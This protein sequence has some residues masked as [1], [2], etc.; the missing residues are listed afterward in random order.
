LGVGVQAAASSSPFN[1]WP[2][3]GLVVGL[4]TLEGIQGVTVK[5][6]KINPV[7]VMMLNDIWLLDFRLAFIHSFARSS[8]R[9]SS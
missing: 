4:S 9:Q 6:A 5:G 1:N 7:S 3:I 2:W 8:I